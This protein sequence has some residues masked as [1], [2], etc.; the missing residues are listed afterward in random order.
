M[1]AETSSAD[2]Q[3][4]LAYA[5]VGLRIDADLEARAMRLAAVLDQFAATCTEYKLGIDGRMADPLFCH[6]PA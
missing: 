6:G 1:D 4:L 3:A 2:P 5:E